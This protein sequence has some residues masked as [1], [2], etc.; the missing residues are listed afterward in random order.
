MAKIA[1]CESELKKEEIQR[2]NFRHRPIALVLEVEKKC[3]LAV[4]QVIMDRFTP[5]HSTLW[6]FE[7]NMSLERGLGILWRRAKEP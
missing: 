7:K 6:E 2:G 3:S 5:Q 1:S 4:V